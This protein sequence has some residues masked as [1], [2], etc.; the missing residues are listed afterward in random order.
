MNHA[1]SP[2]RGD[3]ARHYREQDAAERYEIAIE[4]RADN[5]RDDL[6]AKDLFDMLGD[7][8]DRLMALCD[9]LLRFK[10]CNAFRL[11]LEQR[12]IA[13]A[14]QAITEPWIAAKVAEEIAG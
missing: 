2:V 11:P 5:I 8:A 10:D 12:G 1:I 9:E 4:H 14:L 13:Q 7:D 3:T 6:D